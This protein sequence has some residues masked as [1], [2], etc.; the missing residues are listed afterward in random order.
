MR[1]RSNLYKS[2]PDFGL[3]AAIKNAMKNLF[4][5]LICLGFITSCG[6][7]KKVSKSAYKGK[8]E[9]SVSKG[10][11]KNKRPE[12]AKNTEVKA[13]K[14][15]SVS[16]KEESTASGDLAGQIV[17][18]ARSY[19]GTKYQYG[20]MSEKGIDCSG[21]IYLSFLNAGDIFLPRSSRE[22][23]KQGEKINLKQARKG[24]LVF[25]K[26][27]SRNVIN[28][29]GLVVKNNNGNVEFIHSSTKK[30]VMISHIQEAYWQKAFIE[31]RRI[32]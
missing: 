23:A 2:C 29:L 17:E 10:A 12:I 9:R 13:K 7:S 26:T 27:S 4:I 11:Y 15:G 18:Y 25:F 21:L 1:F 16:A 28:H 22:I 8:Y 30:G 19:M 3:F 6:S 5:L 14:S 31:A 24:D 20:G 32:L